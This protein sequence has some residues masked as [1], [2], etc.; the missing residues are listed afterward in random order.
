M[1]YADVTCPKCGVSYDNKHWS[2]CPKRAGWVRIM[3]DILMRLFYR[4]GVI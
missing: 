3:L 1:I 2:F 4:P